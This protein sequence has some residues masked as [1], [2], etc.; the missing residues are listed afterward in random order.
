[1]GALCIFSNP[2][3]HSF[4]FARRTGPVAFEFSPHPS[5]ILK[6]ERHESACGDTERCSPFP[7]T[8]EATH[9]AR[10]SFVIRQIAFLPAALH[11]KSQVRVSTRVRALVR[12]SPASYGRIRTRKIIIILTARDCGCLAISLRDRNTFGPYPLISSRS[13]PSSN[14]LHS[15]N[16][17]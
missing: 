8:A 7:A 17:D 4:E 13:A 9:V 5:S 1:M 14:P 11:E 6:T 12:V 16:R 10:R 2:A 3:E 15:I